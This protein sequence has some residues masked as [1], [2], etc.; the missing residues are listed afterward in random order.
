MLSFCH[1]KTRSF[2]VKPIIFF[3]SLVPALLLSGC[4]EHREAPDRLV[5][6]TGLESA[7]H[8]RETV[9]KV[10]LGGDT[11]GHLPNE[12]AGM[13]RLECLMLRRA[14]VTNFGVL[15]QLNGLRVLDLSEMQLAQMPGE[16]MSLARL[17]H[18]Y[19]SD[20]ALT[21]LPAAL[22]ALENLTY[23]NLDRNRL[24]ALPEN[25]G[26]LKSLRWLR[27][28]QN[29]LVALPESIGQSTQL[30]RLYLR[31]NRL[32]ALPETLVQCLLIEDL[33]LS[34]NQLA[35]FPELLTRLPRLRNLD[36]SGNPLADF[37]DED[38]LARMQALRLLT[39]THCKVSPEMQKRL[40][41]ALPKCLI[42]F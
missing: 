24:A 41:A 26:A 19:L 10:D 13:P 27:L 2:V 14:A 3:F 21:N 42:T 36:L 32:Q 16:I 25:P 37:P 18:L 40:R 11:L 23:L 6:A 22:S 7:R 9:Q 1:E 29:E 33:A 31:K 20:N 34:E 30:Q 35:A 17:Q 8:L 39:L 4:F 38:T 15:P 12:L 28:N 5:T